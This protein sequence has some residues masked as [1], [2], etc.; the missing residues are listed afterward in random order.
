MLFNRPMHLSLDPAARRAL[1][2]SQIPLEAEPNES[3]HAIPSGRRRDESTIQG[4]CKRKWFNQTYSSVTFFVG[5]PYPSRRNSRAHAI[6]RCPSVP[7]DE[8]GR[9]ASA[10]ASNRRKFGGGEVGSR[11]RAGGALSPRPEVRSSPRRTARGWRGRKRSRSRRRRRRG[12][13]TSRYGRCADGCGGRP[14]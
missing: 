2:L 6:A 13:G 8:T 3:C 12:H 5:S 4:V 9:R 7:V 14:S 10:I 11:L 1:P